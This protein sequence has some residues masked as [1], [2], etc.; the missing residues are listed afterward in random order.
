[1]MASKIFATTLAI[2]LITVSCG[3]IKPNVAEVA[4]DVD[5]S[6][7][8][9][10]VAVGR[11]GGYAGGGYSS[12]AGYGHD[13]AH[14]QDHGGGEGH[15]G[16]GLTAAIV[17]YDGFTALDAVAPY[18]VFSRLPN[19][20]VRFVAQKAGPVQTDTRLLTMI[21]DM[22]L[23]DLPSPDVLLVPGGGRR[24]TTGAATNPVLLQW[25]QRAHD[26][27]RWTTS[28]CTG[29]LILGAAGLLKGKEAT[30]YWSSSDYLAQVGA[31]YLHRRFVQQ[32]KII[33]GAGVSAALDTALA[34][35]ARIAGDEVA[36]SLQLA[37]EYDPKPPYDTGDFTKA[38]LKIRELAGKLVADAD[39]L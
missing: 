39:K 35:A 33:T 24:G 18:E 32:G 16:G 25:I 4:A 19:F 20:T 3:A 10:A 9:I 23:A 22:A 6:A 31:T 38:T 26:T 27:T 12:G 14:E 21:A 29:S 36:S 15:G 34:I 28:V 5:I 7:A 11:R 13:H 2:M 30:T 37:L 1:M 17:L 8:N